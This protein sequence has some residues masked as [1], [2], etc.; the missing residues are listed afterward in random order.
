MIPIE[1]SLIVKHRDYGKSVMLKD[2]PMVGDEITVWNDTRTSGIIV[3]CVGRK[4]DSN[5]GQLAFQCTTQVP[6]DDAIEYL[7]KNGWY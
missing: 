3:K 4:W 7:Q 5:T 6:V 2:I 1:L